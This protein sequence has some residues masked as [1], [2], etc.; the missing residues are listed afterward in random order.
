MFCAFRP[1]GLQGGARPWETGTKDETEI[2]GPH[3]SEVAEASPGQKH[4]KELQ[5]LTLSMARGGW[6]ACD[7]SPK[8]IS[9]EKGPRDPSALPRVPTTEPP[10]TEAPTPE[11]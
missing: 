2:P 8:N 3:G 10:K 4:R 5:E 1:V 11:S 7:Q 9:A 6:I